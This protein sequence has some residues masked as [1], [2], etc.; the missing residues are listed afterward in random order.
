MSDTGGLKVSA[1]G[2]MNL[3]ATARRRWGLVDGGEVGYV[4]LG[5]IVVLVP[6][7]VDQV[8]AG[9][10]DQLTDADWDAARQGFGDPEL[11]DQ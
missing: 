3:P 1:R 6:G 4:D 9:L 5:D 7:G 10:V 11:A 2:Q 8:R